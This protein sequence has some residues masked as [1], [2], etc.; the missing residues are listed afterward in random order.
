MVK[1]IKK[2]FIIIVCV[3]LSGCSTSAN[4]EDNTKG[5][6]INMESYATDDSKAYVYIE[7]EKNNYS[8]YIYKN[9]GNIEY[10][11]YTVNV[12][13]IEGGYS[14]EIIKNEAIN[15]EQCTNILNEVVTLKEYPKV[16]EIVYNQKNLEYV[17][18]DKLVNETN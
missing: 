7:K 10:A 9:M 11:Y 12:R 14:I 17:I 13:D 6:I 1:Q 18:I 15:E 8:M 16:L 4:T 5:K 2:I 3:F